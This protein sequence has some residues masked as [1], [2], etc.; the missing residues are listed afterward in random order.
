MK[1]NHVYRPEFADW[2][3]PLLITMS[4]L[5]LGLTLNR[6]LIK[7]PG[8]KEK[9]IWLA[10]WTLV[11]ALWFSLEY[12]C[13][14]PAFKIEGVELEEFKYGQEVTAKFWAAVVALVG[15]I[16]VKNPT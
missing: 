10:F 2:F 16:A 6:L 11:P 12:H 14:Y 1:S 3:F 7:K 8:E 9:F 15:V 4:I 13:I 5:V